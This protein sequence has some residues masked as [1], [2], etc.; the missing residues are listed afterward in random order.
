MT[1][2]HRNSAPEIKPWEIIC[3]MPPSRPMMAPSAEPLAA[4]TEKPTKKPRVTK[5]ICEMEE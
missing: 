2:T 4:Y 3:I 5:P 1:P